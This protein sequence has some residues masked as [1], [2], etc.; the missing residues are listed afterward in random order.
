MKSIK[1]DGDGAYV[2]VLCKVGVPNREGVVLTEAAAKELFGESSAFARRVK[3]GALRGELWNPTLKGLSNGAANERFHSISEERVCMSL[4][5]FFVNEDGTVQCRVI[6]TGPQGDLA[7]L[8]IDDAASP[9]V[10][11]Y[12]ALTSSR[13]EKGMIVQRIEQLVT[14]DLIYDPTARPERQHA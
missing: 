12:R 10:L 2:A 14:Y 8:L 9:V 7:K 6:P 13:S 4:D 1:P 5:Q 3:A 11:G